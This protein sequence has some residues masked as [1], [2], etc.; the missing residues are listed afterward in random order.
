[1]EEE[2]GGD[3]NISEES[4]NEVKRERSRDKKRKLQAPELNDLER[5]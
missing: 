2:Y 4:D 1:M 3:I 5:K